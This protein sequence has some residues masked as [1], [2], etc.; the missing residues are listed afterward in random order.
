MEFNPFSPEFRADPYAAYA[1]LREESPVNHVEGLGFWTVSRYDDIAFVLKNPNTFSSK[2]IN[3][4]ISGRPTRTIIN[5]D[6][7]EHTDMRNLVNRVFTP[8]MVA[9]LEPRIREIA[10]AL[11]GRVAP[12]GAM[13]FVDDLAIPLPVTVIAEILG[14]EPGRRADFKRWSNAVI[15]ANPGSDEDRA[16]IESDITEFMR[17]FTAVI[18]DRRRHPRGDLIGALIDAEDSDLRLSPDD[19]LAFTGL[20]L[21][22]GN[23]TTTNLLGNAMLALLRHPAQLHQVAADPSLIPNM[24]EE[25]LRYESPVQFLFRTTTRECA[26]AGVTLPADATVVPIYASGNRDHRKF[27]GP[28]RFDITRNTQGHL[29]FGLGMHFCL[30]AP[31]ARLEAKVAF[32]EFF[33]R[34]RNHRLAAEPIRIDHV[35]LRGLRH[36]PLSFD[37]VAVSA[38]G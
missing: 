4:N 11:L 35:F 10:A 1:R 3:L 12:G 23:E 8:R 31:L 25:A 27:P 16:K 20:L 33:A 9:D 7:P 24:V 19:V 30:G 34:T 29:A 6:P 13:D 18:D 38:S 21:I 22:A 5:T 32:E 37:P 28:D 15:G 14:V 26:I 36:L 17:Y 2:A